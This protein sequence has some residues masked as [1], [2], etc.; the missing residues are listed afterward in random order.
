ML[1]LGSTYFIVKNM[2]RSLAFYEAFCGIKASSRNLERWAEFHIGPNCIALFNP[3]YDL[4]L[5]KEN[6]DLEQHYNPEYLRY[7]QETPIR[8]GNQAV[9]NFWVEDLK[10]EYERVRQ[11]GIGK[12]TPI[13][14]I[15]I[16]MPYYCFVLEDPDGNQIEITGQYERRA[17][18][19]SA[20]ESF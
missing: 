10:S 17:N 9:L 4:A 3:E 16:V 1:H 20:S 8:H 7:K 18:A 2:E 12:M 14:Y 15:N 19:E 5:I 11:L 13:L 6:Q